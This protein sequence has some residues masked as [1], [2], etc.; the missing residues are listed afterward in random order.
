MYTVA[1]L[2]ALRQQLG[3]ADA[4]ITEDLRLLMALEVASTAIETRTQRHFIPRLKTLTH[5][6]DLR[7]IKTV[8]LKE[9]LLELQSLTNGDGSVVPLDDTL[10]LSGGLLRLINGQ[11]FIYDEVP[12]DAIQVEAIWG[13]H[14]QWDSAWDDSADSVQDA[15][16]SASATSLT[17][18][19]ADAGDAPRFQIG[20]FLRIENEYLWVTAV[21]TATNILTVE[22]AVQ[23]TT[24]ATHANGTS[25]EIYQVPQD[26]AG[27][28]LQWAL[29]FYREPDSAY[30]KIPLYLLQQLNGLR[31]IT[32]K[33]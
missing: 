30:D 4:D 14:P 16:L 23:G 18:N 12:E 26:I 28:C 9:D 5:N 1:T 17:V 31:R 7:N 20:Q 29:W 32:V 6:V 10:I 21:D 24:A 2:Y 27:L 3:L 22:R 33:A 11:T 19:D 25:I 15:P 13:Y 8:L